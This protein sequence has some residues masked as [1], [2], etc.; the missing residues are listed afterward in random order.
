MIGLDN[1]DDG[2]VDEKRDNEAGQIVGPTD[3]ISDLVQI[4]RF[5]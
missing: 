2:L 3:G 1:D 5:L 4:F